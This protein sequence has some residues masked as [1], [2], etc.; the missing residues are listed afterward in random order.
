MDIEVPIRCFGQAGCLI[1]MVVEIGQGIAEVP[2]SKVAY[3]PILL[4]VCDA[5]AAQG[6]M[7]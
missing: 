6:H 3:C 7:R 4:G 5:G 1:H 2:I